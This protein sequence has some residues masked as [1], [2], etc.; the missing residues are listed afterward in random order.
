MA[1]ANH[2][3]SR[4]IAIFIGSICS[5]IAVFQSGAM[6]DD[7]F[8]RHLSVSSETK[9]AGEFLLPAFTVCAHTQ[10]GGP[11]LNWLIS[12]EDY[13]SKL[14]DKTFREVHEQSQKPDFIIA[15]ALTN[16]NM[17]VD[18]CTEPKIR[19]NWENICYSFFDNHDFRE[20][21]KCDLFKETM[22]LEIQSNMAKSCVKDYCVASMQVVVHRPFEMFDLDTRSLSIELDNIE[23]LEFSVTKT[24]FAIKKDPGIHG[25]CSVYGGRTGYVNRADCLFKC[26]F[27]QFVTRNNAWPGT[28]FGMAMNNSYADLKMSVK[29]I[30]DEDQRYCSQVVCKL[31]DCVKVFYSIQTLA[32]K[33]RRPDNNTTQLLF[34]TPFGTVT[35]QVIRLKISFNEL[36]SQVG[37]VFGLWIGASIFASF[38]LIQKAI[39]RC[40]DKKEADSHKDVLT[41]MWPSPTYRRSL[42]QY[43][44]NWPS[45]IP[46]SDW[47]AFRSY[48]Q[49]PLPVQVELNRVRSKR[50]N[51]FFVDYQ[52]VGGKVSLSR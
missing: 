37:G 1:A 5:L 17:T 8:N 22:L 33:K 31:E 11:G 46:P 3:F 2:P 35:T 23:A 13:S 29:L 39:L 10:F 48:P 6:V 43:T 41:R 7:Y 47:D 36:L 20:L 42:S 51:S 49:K 28:L 32:T 27:E 38:Q 19:V 4:L 18:N 16:P 14:R 52:N 15:C 34:G 21:F 25:I 12:P 50:L 40:V 24:K 9:E 45:V 30:D 26:R 44:H